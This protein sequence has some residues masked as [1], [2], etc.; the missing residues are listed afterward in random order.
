M[1]SDYSSYLNSIPSS[2]QEALLRRISSHFMSL[3]DQLPQAKHL[4]GTSTVVSILVI[5]IFKAKC[6]QPN[7]SRNLSAMWAAAMEFVSRFVILIIAT[8][9]C[10]L[11]SVW[12]LTTP[13][14][15]ACQA[16][17]SMNFPGKNTGLGCHFLPQVI[18]PT[19]GSKLG[20]LYWRVDSLP[21]CDLGST[22]LT[23]VQLLN[24]KQFW[25]KL[26]MLF[27]FPNIL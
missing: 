10:V 24:K 13:W 18:F 20:L 16:P 3:L 14:T 17:W 26:V 4:W 5:L 22:P 1:K 21:P 15:I 8:D 11:S 9:A 19:Q 12:L 27:I 7:I 25:N 23:P 6:F 2:S